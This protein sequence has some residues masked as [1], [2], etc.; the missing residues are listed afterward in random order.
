MKVNLRVKE[1]L[2]HSVDVELPDLY[3]EQLLAK[4]GCLDDA[5]AEE[6]GDIICS[7]NPS[8]TVQNGYF[9]DG[10]AVKA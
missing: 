6:V 10:E 9:E 1:V 3:A 4:D 2:F 5:F 7:H 8:V